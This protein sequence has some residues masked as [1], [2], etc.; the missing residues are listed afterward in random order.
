MPQVASRGVGIAPY[1]GKHAEAAGDSAQEIYRQ[2]AAGEPGPSNSSLLSSGA[3]AA[4]KSMHS[5]ITGRARAGIWVQGYPMGAIVTN[6]QRPA[7]IALP[8]P[9]RWLRA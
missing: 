2:A 8:P 6:V 3:D 1:K 5:T 7:S 9:C 4:S